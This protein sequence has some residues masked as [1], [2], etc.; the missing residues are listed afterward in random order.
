MFWP[1]GAGNEHWSSA[2]IRA[3]LYCLWEFGSNAT[4]QIRKF[5][6][7]FWEFLDQIKSLKLMKANKEKKIEN[8][9]VEWDGEGGAKGKGD[10]ERLS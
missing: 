2:V 10:W 6:S 3:H 9:D 4:K 1:L 7:K 8:K 5:K